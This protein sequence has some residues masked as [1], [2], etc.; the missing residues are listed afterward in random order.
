MLPLV[1]C[2]AIDQSLPLHVAGRVASPD[3]ILGAGIGI[4]Q[5]FVG[6]PAP[7]AVFLFGVGFN[8]MFGF[9]IDFVLDQAPIT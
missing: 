5:T 2:F 9:W 8:P 6:N 3:L 4:F 7:G 1:L